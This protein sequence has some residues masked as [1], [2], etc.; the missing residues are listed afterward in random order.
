MSPSIKY[1]C[2]MCDKTF[3]RK[4]NLNSHIQAFHYSTLMFFQCHKCYTMFTHLH[5][6]KSHISNVCRDRVMT[7]LI[8]KAHVYDEMSEGGHIIH[9]LSPNDSKSK[10]EKEEQE[11]D[12][13]NSV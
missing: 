12:E 7:D 9:E 10:G 11:E 3:T 6:L 4:Y 5:T 1:E 13:K 8:E 2:D